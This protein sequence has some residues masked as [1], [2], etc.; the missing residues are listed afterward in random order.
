MIFKIL[1]I[2]DDS[3]MQDIYHEYFKNI[4][5][6]NVKIK[7]IISSNLFDAESQCNNFKPDCVLLDLT[8]EKHMDGLNISN[9]YDIDKCI[10]ISGLLDVNTIIKC[11]ELGFFKF[12]NKPFTYNLLEKI[13]TQFYINY[14]LYIDLANREEDLKIKLEENKALLNDLQESYYLKDTILSIIPAIIYIKDIDLKY[15]AVNNKF[16]EINNIDNIFKV[17][18]K[19]DYDIFDFERAKKY[20]EEDQKVIYF[21]KPLIDILNTSHSRLKFEWTLTSKYPIHNIG[22]IGIIMDITS[23]IK[24][25][26]IIENTFDAIKDGICIIDSN[27]II[28]K[29]NKTLDNWYSDQ[30]PLVG[31]K[32]IDVFNDMCGIC[33]D[34][35]NKSDYIN[36]EMKYNQ[37]WFEVEYYPIKDTTNIICYRRDITNKKLLEESIKKEVNIYKN[38][39]QEE[40]NNFKLQWVNNSSEFDKNISNSNTLLSSIDLDSITSLLEK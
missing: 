21:N 17:I 11:N 19:T 27:N 24:L 9:F 33:E 12:I 29:T 15:L 25:E 3:I 23:S 14:K 35:P 7:Y 18:G 4:V 37:Y 26:K 20:S 8:L 40:I 30:M 2:E 39:I 1:V 36:C 38:K 13:L 6:D 10:V 34:C 28:I 16:L 31:R 32:C 22:I 5:I